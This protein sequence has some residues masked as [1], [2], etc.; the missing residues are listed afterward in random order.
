[1]GVSTLSDDSA[2]FLNQ[3]QEASGR[4]WAGI[5]II[6]E[7]PLPQSAVDL[8]AAFQQVYAN[9]RAEFASFTVGPETAVP[10]VAKLLAS[11]RSDTWR[12][13]LLMPAVVSSLQGPPAT[14]W[15]VGQSTF[16]PLP[17]TDLVDD[18]TRTLATGGAYRRLAMPEQEARQLADQFCAELVNGHAADVVVAKSVTRW[19]DWFMVVA[20]D[21]SWLGFDRADGRF[22]ILRATDTD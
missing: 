7:R 20:W 15:S 5:E 14:A 21:L 12:A 3:P 1:M 16:N 18:L 22:W 10:L 13:M 4:L 2:A 8:V 6:P 19:S 11:P 17:A 9:G